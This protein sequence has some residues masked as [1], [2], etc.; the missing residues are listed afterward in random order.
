MRP[1][2][3]LDVKRPLGNWRLGDLVLELFDVTGRNCDEKFAR[4]KDK[5]I[6]STLHFTFYRVSYKCCSFNCY[7][8][9]FYRTPCKVPSKSKYS[10]LSQSRAV[11]D[12][13][14]IYLCQKHLTFG[15]SLFWVIAIT[16]FRELHSCKNMINCT[17]LCPTALI[18]L[19]LTNHPPMCCKYLVN[20]EILFLTIS[21]ITIMMFLHFSQV[22]TPS[23]DRNTKDW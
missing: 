11:Y 9:L 13:V 5:R 22:S 16:Q 17:F 8:Q 20:T 6:C 18:L 23:Q 3:A 7:L 19:L 2:V 21:R 15:N 10:C 4:F 12:N 1:R 14:L